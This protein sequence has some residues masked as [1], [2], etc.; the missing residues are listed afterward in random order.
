MLS[1]RNLMFVKSC[2][3]KI[4]KCN[5]AILF[6]CCFLLTYSNRLKIK[7]RG[8]CSSQFISY[9]TFYHASL[10][11]KTTVYI[12]SQFPQDAFFKD[13]EDLEITFCLVSSLGSTILLQIP[14][15]L[16]QDVIWMDLNAAGQENTSGMLWCSSSPLLPGSRHLELAYPY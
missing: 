15:S 7:I 3:I 4:L 8:L 1:E 13:L 10:A 11:Q 6:I 14:K 12:L 5:I 2:K 9:F 16:L